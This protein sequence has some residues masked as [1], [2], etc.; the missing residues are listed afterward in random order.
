MAPQRGPDCLGSHRLSAK[1]VNA[2]NLSNGVFVYDS[3]VLTFGGIV[4]KFN[5]IFCTFWLISFLLSAVSVSPFLLSESPGIQ[6]ERAM[7][8]PCG[9]AHLS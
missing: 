4:S 6:R 1:I 2:L 3:R 5:S 8:I 9:T 7:G